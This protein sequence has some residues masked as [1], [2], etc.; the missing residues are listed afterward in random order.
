MDEAGNIT[1]SLNFG[2]DLTPGAVYFVGLTG[3]Y[4]DFSAEL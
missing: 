4:I 3:G 1:I 2:G